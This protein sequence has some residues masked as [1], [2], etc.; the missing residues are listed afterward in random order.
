MI[1]S[2]MR[3]AARVAAWMMA[4]SAVAHADSLTVEVSGV[5]DAAGRV[6][7]S[8]CGDADGQF[9]G[10]C[11]THSGMADAAEGTV[12]VRIDGVPAGR[13]ALQGFHD[14]NGNYRA[15]IPPEGYAFGN[16]V[17]F[18]PS[19]STAAVEVRGEARTTV[20]MQYAG[21]PSASQ[22]AAQG[23]P[24]ADAPAGVQRQALR[25]QGLVGA[26]YMPEA[27]AASPPLPGL[28][29]LGGS[30]GGLDTISAMA[31]SFAREG[32]AVLALA[33]FAEQ[34]LPATLEN[35]PLEY[36]DRALDWL[37]R[38]PQVDGGRLGVLGWSRGSEAALLLASRHREVKAVIGVAPSGVVWQGLYYGNDRAP[39]PAWT[40]AGRPLPAL[41]PDASLYRPDAPLVG[42]FL[43][44]FDAVQARQDVQIPVE[45]IRGGILLISGGRDAVW[46]AA[47]FADHLSGRLQALRHRG[48]FEHLHYPDAGHAVFVGHP[49]G[50]MATALGTAHPAMGGTPAANRA[51]WQ[52]SWQK[53]LQFLRTEL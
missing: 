46:P 4:G 25:E 32:Y 2:G 49:E 10:G 40:L 16:D 19:F 41:E 12:T 8:L 7:V 31:T 42:L 39:R 28:L 53:T 22:A 30:E 23:S 20:R 27:V 45:R 24:G 35:I 21:S 43:S 44:R 36:F 5:R 33:Y 11:N 14:A 6:L 17:A 3:I 9:P 37:K 26:L 52:D 15:E 47:R 38:Q 29:L 13:Y 18:P 50:P 51:A 34:G 48:H 1:R